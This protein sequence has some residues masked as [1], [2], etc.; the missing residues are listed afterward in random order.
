MYMTNLY[1]ICG[2]QFQQNTYTLAFSVIWLKLYTLIVDGY[3]VSHKTTYNRLIPNYRVTSARH[4][5]VLCLLVT[6]AC[7]VNSDKYHN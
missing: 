1:T 4:V 2:P 5:G 3:W 6:S 7:H